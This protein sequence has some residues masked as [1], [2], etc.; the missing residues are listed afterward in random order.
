MPIKLFLDERRDRLSILLD[1][2]KRM[3][4]IMECR[5]GTTYERA[6]IKF[7]R[8]TDGATATEGRTREL[9]RRERVER[10]V[11]RS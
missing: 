6:R 3:L 2:T 1:S 9:S 5:E 4:Y 7:T 8:R 10:A 11:G